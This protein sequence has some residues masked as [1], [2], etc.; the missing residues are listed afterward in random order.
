[1]CVELQ[2]NIFTVGQVSESKI[3][4]TVDN[5]IILMTSVNDKF[6]SEMGLNRKYCD[7][8]STLILSVAY[9]IKSIVREIPAFLWQK[10]YMSAD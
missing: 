9:G 4:F 10:V 5:F 7:S 3:Q 2:S 6:L 8:M 1:M